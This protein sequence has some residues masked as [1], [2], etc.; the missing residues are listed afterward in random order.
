M[1]ARQENFNFSLWLYLGRQ[2]WE[3]LQKY[4]VILKKRPKEGL[5]KEFARMAG[6]KG[7]FS[8]NLH[9]HLFSFLQLRKCLD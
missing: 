8:K 9:V 3:T 2:C 4:E 5:H 7:N 1:E 6:F